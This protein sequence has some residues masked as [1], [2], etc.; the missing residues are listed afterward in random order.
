MAEMELLN[1]KDWMDNEFTKELPFLKHLMWLL[2]KKRCGI[3]AI[4]GG[5]ICGILTFAACYYSYP[6]NI[7]TVMGYSI[8]IGLVSI[9]IIFK[10]L[11][12]MHAY[13]LRYPTD[14]NVGWE[15]R[16]FRLHKHDANLYQYLRTTDVFMVLFGVI[17]AGDITTLTEITRRLFD[18]PYNKYGTY[19]TINLVCNII[20]DAMKD[21]ATIPF[22]VTSPSA[23]A[24]DDQC[25]IRSV[26]LSNTGEPNP[27]GKKLYHNKRWIEILE[28]ILDKGQRMKTKQFVENWFKWKEKFP[29]DQLK[30]LYANMHNDTNIKL[31]NSIVHYPYEH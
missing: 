14:D 2:N 21:I 31:V 29:E 12:L 4:I 25:T 22:N 19:E 9:P 13:V 18:L 10:M 6:W 15:T 24:I 8:L 11:A 20:R 5:F 23:P 30:K 27:L 3:P 16:Y 28:P 7:P 26:L 1:F 17:E